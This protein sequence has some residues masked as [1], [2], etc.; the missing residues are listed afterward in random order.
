MWCN[1]SDIKTE[2]KYKKYLHWSYLQSED[3][4]LFVPYKNIIFAKNVDNENDYIL[5]DLEIE[6]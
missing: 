2:Y 4:A 6:E 3:I 1:L 5:F